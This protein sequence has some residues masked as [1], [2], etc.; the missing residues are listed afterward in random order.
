MSNAVSVLR[1]RRL[2]LAVVTV[3][4]AVALTAGALFAA[5]QRQPPE[6]QPLAEPSVADVA[7]NGLPAVAMP[8]E[9]SAERVSA[10]PHDSQE[11]IDLP[12][13][14]KEPSRYPN[15][16]SNLNRLA[17][18]SP[19]TRRA[20]NANSESSGQVAEPVLVTFYVDAD[21]LDD[22]KQYLEDNGIYVRNVGEDYIEAHVPP[23][24]LG[25]ASEQPG[26]LSVDTVIPPRPAQSRGNVISQGVGLH[27]ADAWHNA[28]YRGQNVKVGVIDSGFEGFSQLQGSE[29]PSNVTARCYFETARAPSSQIADCEVDGEHGTAVAETLIDVAPEV[30]LYIANPISSGDLRNAAD[31]MAQQGVQVVNMSLGWSVDGPGDGT[32]PFSNSPLKT[33]DVAVSSGITWVNAGGNSARNVWHGKFSDPDGNDWMN[34]TARDAGNTFYLPFDEESSRASRVTAFMRWDDAWGGADCDLNLYLSKRGSDGELTNVAYDVE[35]QN[36]GVDDIPSAFVQFEADNAGDEGY[37]HLFIR[38]EACADTPDWIQLTAWIADDLQYYSPGRHM[39]NPGESGNPGMMAVGATHYSNTNSIAS[40]SSRGPTIDGRTKPDITGIA[41]VESAVYPTVTLDG[42]ECWF[43]GT[44][45][46]APH[47]AGL[48][49]LVRQRFPNY[50]PAQTV[51]YL[52]Q[53]ASERGPSGADNTW[54]SG[55]AALPDPKAGQPAPPPNT[56]PG[57]ILHTSNVTVRNGLNPGEAIV[58]WDAVPGATYYR[59]G[60]VNMEA[61]Y[62]IAKASASGEWQG[63]FW[64]QDANARDITVVDGRAEYT[65]RRLARGVRHAFTV[66]TSQDV[67]RSG[68]YWSGQF[69]WPNQPYWQFLTTAP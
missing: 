21:H 35:A 25:A 22:V 29:L 14:A 47:V 18:K 30:E 51:R 33:I 64:F 24:L 40:Y 59:V 16:D 15:L 54:G 32:S 60:Y 13:I 68:V 31:W 26:V 36:G 34:F 46:S 11:E 1:R 7:A 38:K 20:A 45:A 63:A 19:T 56:D 23:L 9:P 44:S 53:N 6:T 37:Y 43:P 10:H 39:G 61:D 5:G 69:G 4:A 52:Q 66:Q 42:A 41:C 2:A 57:S 48:A 17:E 58:S 28:G 8:P 49:A 67:F 62:P 50:D 3:L 65:I 27:G 55:L 12:P